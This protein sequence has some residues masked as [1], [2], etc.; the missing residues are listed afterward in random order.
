MGGS[1]GVGCGWFF[2]GSLSREESGKRQR[3]G[4]YSRVVFAGR[5][6]FLKQSHFLCYM[7]YIEQW[8]FRW[9]MLQ[10]HRERCPPSLDDLDR[11]VSVEVST[12]NDL[13]HTLKTMEGLL[14]LVPSRTT[15]NSW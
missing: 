11:Q 2:F 7:L 5:H 15:R 9:F 1:F 13:F 4:T 6:V 12:L 14:H 8:G 10:V 3:Q